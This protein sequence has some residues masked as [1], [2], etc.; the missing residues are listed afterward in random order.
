MSIKHKYYYYVNGVYLITEY[1]RPDFEEITDLPWDIYTD[2]IKLAVGYIRWSDNKQNTGYSLPIQEMEIILKAKA[3]GFSAVIMF[4][5]AATSAYRTAA[6]DRH[7]MGEMKEFILR[8]PNAESVIFFD[9]SRVTRL[10]ADFYTDFI[11]PVRKKIP[12]LK[13]FS[14]KLDG[15]WN[16]NDPIVQMRLT[17][18]YEESAKK[19][20]TAYSY[21][22]GV[23]SNASIDNKP[24][25]PGSRY[26]YG[27]TKLSKEDLELIP[28]ETASIV[29]LIF[30][31]Y[32]YG[33]SEKK[34]ATLLENSNVPSPSEYNHWND[35]SVRYILTNQ[36]YKGDLTWFAR[37][38]HT[39]SKKKTFEEISLFSNHHQALISPSLWEI[40]Q[41][42]RDAKNKDRM[43][44]PFLLRNLVFCKECGES[45][46]TKNQTS[47]KSKMDSSFYLCSNCKYKVPKNDLHQKVFDDF[48]M[49]WTREFKS[50]LKSFKKVVSEWKKLCIK[51]LQSLKD[52]IE[53]LRYK[54]AILKKTDEF[55]EEL[56]PAIENQLDFT[57][58][59]K[60]NYN[61]I[62]LRIED[63]L[64]DH[65]SMEIIERFA[66]DIRQYNNEEIRSIFLLSI[67]QIDFDSKRNHFNIE[68]R[69]SPYVEIETLMNQS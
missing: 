2:S 50:Q 56:Y 17:L 7:K 68:Y 55:Y 22:N 39:N 53:N 62:L 28:D 52:D 23:I 57:E 54:L 21:H 30:Y 63:L 8:N 4:V 41:F 40:T 69:L 15:E 35:S 18:A 65:M 37:T 34:I 38:S 59:Q 61:H 13:L 42:F 26:P 16:E 64:D 5:E 36:W 3:L 43:Y 11:V 1:K 31:L 60:L 20:T 29:Q 48:T 67:K 10:I 51:T 32:S 19:S 24:K 49:R 9:E 25:R 33:Y 14:T 46:K 45:L 6:R 12:E 47:S 58:K 66:Q 27:Y 44:S